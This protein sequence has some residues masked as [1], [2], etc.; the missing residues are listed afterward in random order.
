MTQSLPST[1][2]R[3]SQMTGRVVKI[4][5]I[6][7]QKWGNV[8]NCIHS[9]MPHAMRSTG[10]SLS[11]KLMH[12]DPISWLLGLPHL[13]IQSSGIGISVVS[14]FLMVIFMVQQEIHDITKILCFV[15]EL[16][17]SWMARVVSIVEM[18]RGFSLQ[19]GRS[20]CHKGLC[21]SHSKV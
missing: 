12:C 15:W 6:S 1:L 10:L 4:V 18:V 2:Q 16:K 20:I 9:M 14:L 3:I 17:L 8:Q 11:V 7:P 5:F 21:M 13:L 19:Q